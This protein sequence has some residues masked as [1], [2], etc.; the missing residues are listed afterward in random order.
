MLFES[1][2]R[3]R[4]HGS[5][6]HGVSGQVGDRIAPQCDRVDT[7][8]GEDPG[9]AGGGNLVSDDERPGIAIGVGAA[10]GGRTRDAGGRSVRPRRGEDLNDRARQARRRDGHVVG[11]RDREGVGIE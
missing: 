6:G 10:D 5:G 9:S 3:E 7:V 8:V 11:E 1:S 4:A 2:H